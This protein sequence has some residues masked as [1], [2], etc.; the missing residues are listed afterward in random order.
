[1]KL[2]VT[3]CLSLL[4]FISG[5]QAQD[6][7]KPAQEPREIKVTLQIAGKDAAYITCKGDV[8]FQSPCRYDAATSTFIFA[9]PNDEMMFEGDKNAGNQ[10]DEKTG[11]MTFPGE[12]KVYM[13]AGDKPTGFNI[14]TAIGATV[15]LL[16]PTL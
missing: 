7:A 8:A 15:K 9:I 12:V 3:L 13:R 4:L 1:M 2:F 10:Y 14:L 16:P 5:A 6:P 11:I